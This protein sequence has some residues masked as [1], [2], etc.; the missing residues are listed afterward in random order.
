MPITT[1]LWFDG[2]ADE[3]VAWYLSIF[4]DGSSG[5]ASTYPEDSPG[6]PGSAR[7]VNFELMGSHFLALNGG[8]EYAFTPAV[9][10][11]IPCK[12]QAEVDHSWDRLVE[13]GVPSRCGWLKD[14]FGISWQVVPDRSG[15]LIGDADPGR[16]RRAMQAM[17]TVSALDIAALEAAADGK[18]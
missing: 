3:A 16:A 8:P 12:D 2:I 9:S 17:L 1:C 6:E 13:G 5:A 10:F 7:T 11:M 14:R 15:E 4:K 18:S